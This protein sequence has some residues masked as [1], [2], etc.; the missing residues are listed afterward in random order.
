M[1][2]YTPNYL[3]DS[4][5]GKLGNS[6]FS[7]NKGCHY[8]KPLVIPSNPK[9]AT[10]ISARAIFKTVAAIWST[11]T[12]GQRD[13]WTTWANTGYKPLDPRTWTLAYTGRQAFSALEIAARWYTNFKTTMSITTQT[14]YVTGVASTPTLDTVAPVTTPPTALTGD[15]SMICFGDTF[16]ITNVN[17]IAQTNNTKRIELTTDHNIGAATYTDALMKFGGQVGSP[18]LYLSPKLPFNGYKTK[19]PFSS[20][21]FEFQ[22]IQKFTVTVATPGTKVAFLISSSAT[23]WTPL[24]GIYLA[25]LVW[26]TKDGQQLKIREDYVTM[27]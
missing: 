19:E 20:K 11:L 22:P 8:L 6:V 25:T 4:Y 2:R 17:V 23:P 10:Q 24:T 1:A 7:K 27:P 26:F 15:T 9:T 21:F 12:T 18:G 3:M 16:I 5:A 14:V 13:A